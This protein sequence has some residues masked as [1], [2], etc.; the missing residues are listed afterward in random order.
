MAHP[1]QD[2]ILEQKVIRRDGMVPEQIGARVLSGYTL[3]RR[4]LGAGHAV[5]LFVDVAIQVVRGI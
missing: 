4:T 1:S 5:R 3:H 2:D